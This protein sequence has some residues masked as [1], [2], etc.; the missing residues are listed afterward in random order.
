MTTNCLA[1]WS[2]SADGRWVPVYRNQPALGQMIGGST[3]IPLWLIAVG[4]G[5]FFFRGTAKAA[6]DVGETVAQKGLK[7]L[8]YGIEKIPEPRKKLAPLQPQSPQQL[9]QVQYRSP[10][11][12]FWP[13]QR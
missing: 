3:G 6:A 5:I 2:Q 8:K 9:Q 4:L 13:P 10:G 7:Y 12:T 1:G 11:G